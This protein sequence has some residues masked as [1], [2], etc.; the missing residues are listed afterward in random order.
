MA[1]NIPKIKKISKKVKEE[2]KEEFLLNVPNS[3]TILRLILVFA[4]IYMLFAGYSKISLITVFI[5]AAASDWFDGY[6]ARKLNQATVI[7]ARMDQVIDR[8][9]TI[10]IVLSLMIFLLINNNQENIIIFL[11]LVSS[12]E[13]IG[14][15]GFL[16][17]LIKNKDSYKVKYIGKV[18]TFL[19]SIA[20][21]ALILNVNWVIYPVMITCIVGIISGTDYLIYSLEK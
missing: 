18:T 10:S 11:F 15:P 13:I 8:V 12:R 14:L 1:K 7:G 9:F 6:F 20:L 21:G 19:Q 2:V 3:I 16:I 4:F 17:N 5:I